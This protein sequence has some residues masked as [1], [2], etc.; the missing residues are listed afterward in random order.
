[1]ALASCLEVA[2]SPRTAGK[3]D[4]GGG[5]RGGRGGEET[6]QPGLAHSP[7]PP[8]EVLDWVSWGEHRA[9]GSTGGARGNMPGKGR[10]VRRGT[11]HSSSL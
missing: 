8:P 4:G 9:A 5:G 3:G 10:Q 6:H 11:H 7:P 2:H 1:M